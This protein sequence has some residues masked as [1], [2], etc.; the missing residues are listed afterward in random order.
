MVL[1]DYEIIEDNSV[2]DSENC[3]D[4]NGICLICGNHSINR[5]YDSHDGPCI[6]YNF[7]IKCPPIPIDQ[8][9]PQKL[10]E[11]EIKEAPN[12]KLK[13]L[14]VQYIETSTSE[15]IFYTLTGIGPNPNYKK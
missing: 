6:E 10:T 12:T 1:T 15:E 14:Q 8:N 11:Y 7:K 13:L 3:I 9:N 5:L 2:I 4:S